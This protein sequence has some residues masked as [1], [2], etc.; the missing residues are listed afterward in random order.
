VA[1]QIPQGRVLSIDAAGEPVRAV[2][3]VVDGLRCARCAAG[4]GCGA[5]MLGSGPRRIEASVSD[6]LQLR[7]GDHVR[8]ELAPG[9]LLRAAIIV[10]GIPLGLALLGASLAWWSGAGDAAASLAALAGAAIGMALGRRQLGRAGCL[11]SFTPTISARVA[12][13]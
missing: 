2:V 8:L 6:H 13:R 9:R 10:Y 12:D 11:L 7:E 3:E 1:V 4:K 5:G